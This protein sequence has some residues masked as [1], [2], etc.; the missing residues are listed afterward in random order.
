M[1]KHRI[2]Y[3][4]LAAFIL[5]SSFSLSA[6]Q[7]RRQNQPQ[8]PQS[9]MKD[10]QAFKDL[11]YIKNG[12]ER[13]KLDIYLPKNYK[14]QK[15][16]PVIVWIHG[17]AWRAGDKANC[18]S[19]IFIKDGFAAVSINYRLSQHAIWP[20]QIQD[21]KA[22]IRY[23]RAN[24]KKYNLDPDRIGVWGSSAGGHLVAMLG[25]T[26][27]YKKFTLFSTISVLCAVLNDTGY[28]SNLCY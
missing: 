25:T 22:A 21:C 13:N 19:R 9:Q 27:D 10:T 20:A 26:S 23:L 5:T 6:Q 15:P 8:R 2:S 28:E 16:L 17:G 14:E 3:L 11:E 24:A 12:H 18:R 1:K 7:Q 4:L